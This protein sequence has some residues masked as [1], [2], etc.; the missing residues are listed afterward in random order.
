GGEEQVGA[1]GG[2][3]A[4]EDDLAAASGG[5]RGEPARLVKFLV[6]GQE[7]LRHDAEDAAA[8]EN[9]GAV[10]ELI[11]HRQRQGHDP[12]A[13]K[14]RCTGA[15]EVVEGGNGTAL[16]GELLEKIGT[17]VAGQRQLGEDEE[18]N[19]LFLSAPHQ[20]EEAFGVEGAVSDAEGGRRRGDADKA[21]A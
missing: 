1:K 7:R 2:G 6:I 4:V 17:G 15:G 3:F 10:G 5:G 13:G 19:A 18:G 21:V 16:E 20:G 9:G 14:D 12:Q 8:V 11:V